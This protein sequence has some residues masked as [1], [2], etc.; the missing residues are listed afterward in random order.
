[1]GSTREIWAPI[2]LRCRDGLG[3][4]QVDRLSEEGFGLSH[5]EVMDRV[6]AAGT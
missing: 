2:Q 1:M 3:P 5:D 4:E 6:H